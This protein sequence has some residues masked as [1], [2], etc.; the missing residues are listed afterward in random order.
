[1]LTDVT[2]KIST[3]LGTLPFNALPIMDGKGAWRDNLM[4]ARLWRSLK[5]A[6]LYLNAFKTGPEMRA[7]LG[8]RL[9]Y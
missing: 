8:K 4:I 6:C 7:G 9:I 2:V 5:Y 3:P 1:M